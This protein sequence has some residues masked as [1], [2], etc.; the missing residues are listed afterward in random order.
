MA[1]LGLGRG[2]FPKRDGCAESEGMNRVSQV[3]RDGRQSKQK[4]SLYRGA[5]D[6]R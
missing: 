2:G 1:P 3:S 5:E 6:K 4:D